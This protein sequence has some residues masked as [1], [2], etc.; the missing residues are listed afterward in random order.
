M[1]EA[2][3]AHSG[4]DGAAMLGAWA[5]ATVAFYLDSLAVHDMLFFE[6]GVPTREGLVDTLVTDHLTGLLPGPETEARALAV[7][8]FS[9]V[10][11]LVDDAILREK[12][13]DRDSLA[14]RAKQL[15][16]RAAGL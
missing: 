1:R 4:P 14:R 12:T 2:V 8:L 15:C 16:L 6:A 3:E 11:A 13:V 7:F 10:H 9:G 5:E